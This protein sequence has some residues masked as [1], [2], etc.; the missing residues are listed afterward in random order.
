ME[1]GQL[2]NVGYAFANASIY[3]TF[4]LPAHS[5]IFFSGL[6]TG[7]MNEFEQPNNSLAGFADTYAQLSI[8]NVPWINYGDAGEVFLN[9]HSFGTPNAISF[10]EIIAFD[11]TNLTD[12]DITLKL[13]MG[14][15]AS[16][17]RYGSAIPEP[18]TYGMLSGGLLLL[19]AV[20]RRKSKQDRT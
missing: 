9:R 12:K 18:A 1:K 3:S 10:S 11:Y 5:T 4:V 2:Q 13:D 20:A 17:N 7:Y 14:V 19:G 6:A 16:I 15:S 8:I